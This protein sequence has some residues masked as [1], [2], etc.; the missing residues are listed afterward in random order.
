M[1]R[2]ILRQGG[3]GLFEMPP[4]PSSIGSAT[5]CQIRLAGV[6]VAPVHCRLEPEEDGYALRALSVTAVNGR[7]VSRCRLRHGDRIEIGTSVLVYE[8]APSPVAPVAGPAGR[9]AARAPR[10]TTCTRRLA[11]RTATRRTATRPAAGG[12]SDPG[13]GL[14]GAGRSSTGP[15]R[16]NQ[17]V[18]I[19]VGAAVFLLIVIAAMS[20][21]SDSAGRRASVD[22][23]QLL[24]R[25]LSEVN[26]LRIRGSLAEA[27]RRLET[28]ILAEPRFRSS[29]RLRDCRKLAEQFRSELNH[30][31]RGVEASAALTARIEAAKRDGTALKRAKEFLD[32][33]LQLLGRYGTTPAAPA[34]RDQRDELRRWVATESQSDWQNDYNRVKSQ[35]ASRFIEAGAYGAAIREWRKFGEVSQDAIFQTRIEAEINAV[36]AAAREAAER[37]VRDADPK[38]LEEALPQFSGTAGQA[39]LAR[40]AKPALPPN[41]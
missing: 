20:G 25:R 22:A 17:R 37:L 26:D 2:L 18:L 24:S 29:A 27:L 28:D 12:P 15:D 11:T 10:T 38:A 14:D 31:Q 19:G 23:E 30:D 41:K 1:A 6:G 39:I 4:H 21:K 32:E 13:A 8:D 5:S 33:C 36:N 34:L 40:K 7:R 35:I 9:P 3:A 16:S